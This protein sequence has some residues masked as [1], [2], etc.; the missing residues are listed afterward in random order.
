MGP[1]S[2]EKDETSMNDG[3]PVTDL[4][5]SS[6]VYS[7]ELGAAYHGDS[8]QLLKELPEDSIDLIVT[9]PPFALQHEK[10]YGNEDQEAYNDWFMEFVPDVERVLQP[11]GSF[12]VEIGGAF[13]QG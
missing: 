8:R 1:S 4:L 5:E 10:E 2:I 6:P 3:P 11:H 13:E 9:S 7:T 12:I